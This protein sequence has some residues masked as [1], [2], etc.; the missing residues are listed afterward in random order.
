MT[1]QFTSANIPAI[2]EFIRS[3]SDDST[4]VIGPVVWQP[5]DGEK[6]KREYF[7]VAVASKAAG[8]WVTQVVIQE[9]QDRTDIIQELMVTKPPLIIH[10]TDDEL[11]MAQLCE[12]LWPSE[13]TRAIREAVQSERA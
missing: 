5:S 10:T 13:K 12:A 11:Y 1:K 6:A 4:A 8:F 3:K 9:P 2:V 7:I